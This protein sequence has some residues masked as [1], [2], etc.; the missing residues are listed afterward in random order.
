VSK[1]TGQHITV[2]EVMQLP[3]FFAYEGDHTRKSVL[4][5]ILHLCKTVIR[6]GGGSR[7]FP[8][9]EKY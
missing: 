7:L 5:L 3:A 1:N 4:A 6:R 9:Q 2:K 8:V